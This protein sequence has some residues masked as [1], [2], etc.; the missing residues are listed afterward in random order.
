M[1]VEHG[2]GGS[3]AAAPIARDIMLFALYGQVP[4]LEGYPSS[5]RGRMETLLSE[6]PLRDDFRPSD[7]RGRA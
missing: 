3:S 7:R 6:L 5:Q 4:P 1:V 2:G